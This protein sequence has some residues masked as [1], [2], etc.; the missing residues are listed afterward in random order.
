MIDIKD[1][2]RVSLSK[3]LRIFPTAS[4]VVEQPRAAQVILFHL[5]IPGRTPVLF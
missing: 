2:F 3:R 4:P 5:L 1:F